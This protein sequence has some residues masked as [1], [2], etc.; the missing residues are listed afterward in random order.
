MS[1]S[2]RVL[3]SPV[4]L[5]EPAAVHALFGEGR[6]FGV[7]LPLIAMYAGIDVVRGLNFRIVELTVLIYLVNRSWWMVV[8]ARRATGILPGG[9]SGAHEDS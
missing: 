4:L 2:L 5:F 1:M 8:A 9:W 6:A 3:F 7:G